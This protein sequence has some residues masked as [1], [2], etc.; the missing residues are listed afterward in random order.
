M[1]RVM[2]GAAMAALVVCGTTSA[3]AIIVYDPT[4][5]AQNALQAARALQ[6]INQQI[7]ALQNQATMIETMLRNLDHLDTSSLSAM[8][9][10]LTD[11]Q[12]LV[13]Q[14]QGLSAAAA[15]LD[16]RMKAL[17]PTTSPSSMAQAGQQ[18]DQRLQTQ[19]ASFQDAMRTQGHILAAVGD[20]QTTLAA[21]AA[22]SDRANGNLA[23]TQATNQLLALAAKQQA[24]L[25]TM[26][27]VRFQADALNSADQVQRRSDAQVEMR[28]FLGNGQAYTPQ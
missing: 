17:F 9:G 16:Q 5:Y 27:A 20:D 4:N 26:L 21:V 3:D 7:Q 23:V 24:Q 25:Q 22:A 12:R 13:G 15:S 2:R 11:L 6:Q 1:K 18:A 10:Q 19:M 28:R 14:G 8:T